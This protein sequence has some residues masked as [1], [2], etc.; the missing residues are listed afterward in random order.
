MS[1]ALIIGGTGMIGRASAERLLKSGWHVDV[2]GRNPAHMPAEVAAAGGRFIAADRADRSQLAAAMGAGVDLVVDCICYTAAEAAVLLPLLGDAGSTVMLSSKAVYVDAAGNHS[3]SDVEPHFAGPIREDQP[4]MAPGSGDHNTRE[5][6][7]ANKVAA[8]QVLLDSGMPVTVLRPSRVHGPGATRPR[9][10]FFVKRV[11]DR[12]PTLLLARAADVVHTTATSN[13]AALVEAVA[14]RP[15][16]RILNSADPDAPDA[17]Q[18]SRAIAGRLGHTWREVLLPDGPLGRHPWLAEH[19]V[20]LDMSAAIAL[21]YR[22]AGDFATT[23]ADE[24]D[25]LVS[26]GQVPGM[27][28]Y[29][30]YAAEDAYLADHPELADPQEAR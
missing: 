10:W 22:P 8:E 13:I 25:W 5:G 2:T 21:G 20:V 19:P 6:Y 29:F 12:R 4:T 30:D 24:I 15:G 28:E 1:H 17:L 18:I 16:R 9:E 14:A 23:V 3:N 11:L 26:T 27:D 7:G